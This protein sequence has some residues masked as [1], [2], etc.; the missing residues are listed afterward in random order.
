MSTYLV[1]RLIPARPTFVEDM[2][3]DEAAIVAEHAEHWRPQLEAGKLVVFGPVL[4]ASGAW[5]LGVLEAD[6]EEDALALSGTHL[7]VTSGIGRY[8]VGTM[9]SGFVRPQQ[10]N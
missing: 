9:L 2:T 4:D 7:A 1:F 6:S 8:E 5:G 3:P 10:A